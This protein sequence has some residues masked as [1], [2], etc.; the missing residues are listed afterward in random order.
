MLLSLLHQPTS[1]PTDRPTDRRPTD[2]STSQVKNLQCRV[3]LEKLF[4]AKQTVN[5]LTS[6]VGNFTAVFLKFRHWI[7]FIIILIQSGGCK[8]HTKCS[9]NTCRKDTT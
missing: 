8:L 6:E 2:Q 9:Y 5:S 3:F 7:I 1:E 4:V